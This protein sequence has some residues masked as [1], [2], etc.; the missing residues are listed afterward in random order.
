MKLQVK[1]ELHNLSIN[2][3][4]RC[5]VTCPCSKILLITKIAKLNV[6]SSVKNNF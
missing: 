3:K 6:E 1:L 2:A 5:G 4:S